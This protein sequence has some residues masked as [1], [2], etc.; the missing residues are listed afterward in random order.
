MLDAN[1]AV[2]DIRIDGQ[3]VE[4][5]EGEMVAGVL[6][7]MEPLFARI[8]PVSCAKRAPYCMMG[9][10][11]ECLVKIDGVGSIQSCLAPVQEGMSVE[12]QTGKREMK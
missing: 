4:A 11:F 7:R 3:P 9:V 8:N 12:R 1:R 6:V 2:V 5:F 10:C